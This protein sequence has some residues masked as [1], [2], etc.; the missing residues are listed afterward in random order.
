MKKMKIIG[1]SG[2]LRTGSSASAVLNIVARLVP[3]PVKFEIYNGLAEIS[4]FNDSNEVPDDV[5]KFI[6]LITHADAVFFCIP[7]Y[8][9]GI[10]GALKNVLDWTV[11]STAFS[12]KPV[13][14]ITAASSG[15]KAHAALILTLKALGA[16]MPEGSK[17]LISFI[18]S[19]LTETNELKDIPTLDAIKKV[20]QSL[21]QTVKTVQTNPVN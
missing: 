16:N 4:P 21:L 7:E 13:A 19:K 20:I 17:L 2:S 11:S 10:P 3:A 6:Q 8:A 15:D 18:R 5:V 1:I 9:F 12:D 14:I